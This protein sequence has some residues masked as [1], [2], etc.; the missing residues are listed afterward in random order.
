MIIFL[1][2]SREKILKQGEIYWVN[3]SPTKGN[4]IKKIRPVIVLNG[5]HEKNLK[6]SIVVPVTA[7]SP[8]WNKN[9]FFVP[10][11]PNPKNGL[12][13]KSAIDCFQVRSLS[14]NRFTDK[15]GDITPS[16]INFIKKAIALILDIES[17]HC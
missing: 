16:E 5:G 2:L 10:L 6:L 15:I 12:K 8:Y 9:P 13:K 3:L 14:H 4:E 11:E 1:N 7:W 17:R